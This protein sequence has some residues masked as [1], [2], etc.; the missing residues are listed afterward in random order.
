MDLKS[1]GKFAKGIGVTTIGRVSIK[2][3]NK[4]DKNSSKNEPTGNF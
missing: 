4:E 3:K 1:V 2:E